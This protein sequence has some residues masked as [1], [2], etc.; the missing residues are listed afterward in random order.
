M[1]RSFAL[2]RERSTRSILGCG[3]H[4]FAARY[5]LIAPL[6]SVWP[7][8]NVAHGADWGGCAMPNAKRLLDQFLT[9]QSG[10]R[11]HGKGFDPSQLA[12]LARGLG[13]GHL[14]GGA[15]AGSLA[16]ILLGSRQGR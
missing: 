7:D 12:G 6:T 11:I 15:L 14:G 16:G 8:R 2:V 5:G 10:G 9:G 3:D 1:R 13:G 4:G